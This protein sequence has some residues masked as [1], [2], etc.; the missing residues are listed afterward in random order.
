MLDSFEDRRRE[1]ARLDTLLEARS[2]K[3]QQLLEAAQGLTRS[4][5]FLRRTILAGHEKG[6]SLGELSKATGLSREEVELI[7][8]QAGSGR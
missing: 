3:L 6:R 2:K 5:A 8:D 4:P 1:L 7:V